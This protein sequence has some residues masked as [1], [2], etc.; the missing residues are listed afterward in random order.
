M[1]NGCRARVRFRYS[2]SIRKGNTM[3]VDKKREPR[4]LK[5][6]D[7]GRRSAAWKGWRLIGE[8]LV[9]P[10]P[11]LR[12]SVDDANAM[13]LIHARLEEQRIEIQSLREE[14]ERLHELRRMQE[15]PHPDAWNV[16]TLYP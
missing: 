6:T 3:T 12:I 10:A 13:P 2:F 1:V 8:E 15:Q 9:G 11:D 5:G 4:V 7:L 16:P 14:V